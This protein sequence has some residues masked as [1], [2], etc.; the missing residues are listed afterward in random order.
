MLIKKVGLDLHGVIDS[1]PEFFSALS[2]DLVSTGW[3]VHIITGPTRT[4]AQ[5]EIDKFNIEFTHF[6][7]IEDFHIENKTQVSYD[8]KGN[9]WLDENLW[10]KTKADYCHRNN[11]LLHLDDTS[12][13]Q[14]H[15]L[16]HFALFQKPCV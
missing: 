16:T 14:K 9:P 12:R 15:F 7:S 5:K 6:F 8:E 3:E 10:N 1:F 4:K 2:K 11:I 13:Y